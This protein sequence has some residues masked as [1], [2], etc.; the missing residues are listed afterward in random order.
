[1]PGSILAKRSLHISHFLHSVLSIPGRHLSRPSTYHFDGQP[2]RSN[3]MQIVSAVESK[4][5]VRKSACEEVKYRID[6]KAKH[7]DMYS[8]GAIEVR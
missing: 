3:E 2:G 5:K 1:M 8:S 6:Q 4:I 7:F